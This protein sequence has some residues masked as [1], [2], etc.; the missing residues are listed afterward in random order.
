LESGVKNADNNDCNRPM[1]AEP[2]TINNNK[3][4]NVGEIAGLSFFFGLFF[5][6]V[7]KMKNYFL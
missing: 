5:C 6:C 1:T 4:T 2:T 3:P 7:E